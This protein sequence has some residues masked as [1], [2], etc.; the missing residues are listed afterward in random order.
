MAPNMKSNLSLRS[1]IWINV[2]WPDT[3]FPAEAV[4]H[5][6]GDL[7]IELDDI[8]CR[9]RNV[10]EQRLTPKQLEEFLAYRFFL[11]HGQHGLAFDDR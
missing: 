11:P 3:T 5:M 10:V 1:N 4:N 8:G 9:H 2:E 7:R 6:P